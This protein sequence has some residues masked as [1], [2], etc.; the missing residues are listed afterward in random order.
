MT[1]CN[2]PCAIVRR[3]LQTARYLATLVRVHRALTSPEP[4]QSYRRK[5][6]RDELA[7]V[8]G[9]ALRVETLSFLASRVARW[10]L[11][12]IGGP[13][14]RDSRPRQRSTC[15][16]NGDSRRDMHTPSQHGASRT[17]TRA[18]WTRGRIVGVWDR[19]ASQSAC[20]VS[21][22]STTVRRAGARP[23]ANSSR[24]ACDETSHPAMDSR[25]SP[26]RAP[27]FFGNRAC[28]HFSVHL[29][30]S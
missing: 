26:P 12:K 2:S 19:D 18:V 14:S 20:T 1:P 13:T 11:A 9:S 3:S 15:G 10:P 21:D 24:T 6:A 23:D 22:E 7:E 28:K 29:E 17:N 25:L 5:M 16:S 27:S 8:A 30:R 4:K